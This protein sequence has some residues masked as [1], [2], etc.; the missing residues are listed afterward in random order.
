[1]NKFELAEMEDRIVLPNGDRICSSM[2]TPSQLMWHE[3][4]KEK[5]SSKTIKEYRI[6]S[7]SSSYNLSKTVNKYIKKGWEPVGGVCNTQ[8]HFFD[9]FYQAMVKN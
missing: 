5:L 1:M 4:E 3:R 9:F 2:A 8:G 6:V 7:E